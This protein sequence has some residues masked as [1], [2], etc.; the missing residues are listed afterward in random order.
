MTEGN[1]TSAR[2][3]PHT[4]R[5]TVGVG[6]VGPGGGNPDGQT[7]E[8]TGGN[9]KV[10]VNPDWL[11]N[12][13]PAAVAANPFVRAHARCVC[14]GLL[15]AQVFTLVA[16]FGLTPSTMEELL[17]EVADELVGPG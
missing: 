7:H 5:P 17:R 15:A 14:K 2:G 13:S 10:F 9:G 16:Q 12:A 11:K 8:A 6:A 1:E 3:T 4:V